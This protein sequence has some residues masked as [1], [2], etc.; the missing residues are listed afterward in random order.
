MKISN[1][2]KFSA[3][4]VLACSQAFAMTYYSG[5]K[6]APE[7]NLKY[8]TCQWGSSG[9]F[10]TPALPGKP[11]KT[12]TLFVRWG[13]YR[14]DLDANVD[15]QRKAR[16]FGRYPRRRTRRQRIRQLSGKVRRQLFH[17]VLGRLQKYRDFQLH[18][19]RHHLGDGGNNRVHNPRISVN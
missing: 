3:L 18:F 12:D 17:F 14:L 5:L 15:H 1:L 13:G 2:I 9:D 16:L 7:R 8:S 19:A 4:A 6:S 11:G 10:E